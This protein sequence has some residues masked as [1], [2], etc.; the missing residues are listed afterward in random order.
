MQK[1]CSV[2]GLRI[3]KESHLE[4]PNGFVEGHSHSESP[5]DEAYE[6]DPEE[7]D[8]E[9]ATE[10]PEVWSDRRTPQGNY[11]KHL[12]ILI[13]FD[14]IWL[15][16]VWSLANNISRCLITLCLLYLRWEM[17]VDWDSCNR[18]GLLGQPEDVADTELWNVR[19]LGRRACFRIR[20]SRGALHKICLCK[21]KKSEFHHVNG[22]K[23]NFIGIFHTFEFEIIYL[24]CL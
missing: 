23:W 2:C 15:R 24:F 8:E 17:G 6:K 22:W 4:E 9:F 10:E 21:E 3:A 1:Q 12:K 16:F 11:R 14:R 19:R 20:Q 13:M 5:R 7:D 18:S